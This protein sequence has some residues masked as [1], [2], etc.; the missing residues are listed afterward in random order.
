MKRRKALVALMVTMSTLLAV[1][2]PVYA[3]LEDLKPS[4]SGSQTEQNNNKYSGEGAPDMEVI[5]QEAESARETIDK[6]EW[7]INERNNTIRVNFNKGITRF[8]VFYTAGT[9]PYIAFLTPDGDI[10]ESG[11][12]SDTIISRDGN[13]IQGHSDLRYEVIYIV[14]PSNTNDIKAKISLD[15]K[16][17]DFMM[18]KSRVPQGWENFTQEFRTEP[19]ELVSWGF[20]NSENTITD[21]I[22]IAENTD[23]KPVDD[24]IGTAEPPKR[25][26]KDNSGM[27]ISLFV[28]IIIGAGAMLVFNNMSKKRRAKEAVDKRIKK[29]NIIAKK[30]KIANEKTLDNV[31]DEFKDDYSDDDFFADAKPIDEDSVTMPLEKKVAFVETDEQGE[32]I[33]PEEPKP[34]EEKPKQE[35]APVTAPIQTEEKKQE[36]SPAENNPVYKKPATKPSWM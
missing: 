19:E 7:D 9:T 20:H 32:P 11:K 8:E 13:Q 5:S 28:V 27:I 23:I 29:R 6:Y 21:L 26:K 14:A 17:H 33:M 12:D 3:S 18:I 34:V 35:E 2:Q 30:H 16:T 1:A 36:Q 24:S 15:S 10:Y 22:A 4:G 25:E 31:L